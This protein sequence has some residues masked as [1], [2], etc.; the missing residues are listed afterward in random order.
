MHSELSVL[1]SPRRPT[2]TH[3]ETA[4]LVDIPAGKGFRAAA[5]ASL[6]E[7]AAQRTPLYLLLDDVPVATLISGYACLFSG[8]L[9][10]RASR[11]HVTEDIC[12]GWRSDGQMMVSVRAGHGVPVA[13][14]PVAPVLEPADDEWSWHS[15]APL[16]P[17]A[18]RRGR[19]VES[20]GDTFW[21]YFRDSHVMADRVEA[22]LHEY[23]A[24]GTLQRGVIT[25]CTATPRVLPWQECPDAAASASRITGQTV[26]A[27]R[28]MVQRE[29]TGTTTCTHLNDLLRSLADLPLA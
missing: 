26:T 27:L 14:G 28:E 11:Q 8:E 25:S 9:D 6:P 19:L 5:A 22:V 3:A 7:H 2:P 21:A 15:M 4:S 13:A 23:V 18:M 16:T 1:W 10:T 24:E 29:L 17:G 12:S 20:D